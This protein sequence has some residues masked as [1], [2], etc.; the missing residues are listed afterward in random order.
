[1]LGLNIITYK[2]VKKSKWHKGLVPHYNWPFTVVAY[3]RR[4][5]HQIN[6]LRIL[7]VH[8]LFCVLKLKKYIPDN[9]EA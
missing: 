5:V 2:V 7:A 8:L 1:M 9:K 3:I 4:L 6:F